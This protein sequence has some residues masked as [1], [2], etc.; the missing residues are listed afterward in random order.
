NTATFQGGVYPNGNDTTY[1][2]QYG[3]TTSYGQTTPNTDIG[4]GTAP[5]Q[6]SDTITGLAP[7]TTYHYQ[8][9]AVSPDTGTEFPGYD[10]TFT[11]SDTGN[12]VGSGGAGG[13]GG[14]GGGG[15]GGGTGDGAGGSTGGGGTTG[16]SGGSG[17]GGGSGG[18]TGITHATN[19]PQ[20]GSV[21][22]QALGS[23]SATV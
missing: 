15:T 21:R 18:Q 9:V 14:S 7:N 11:T 13:G 16:G 1:F 12:S 2:W 23:S 3:T 19:A 22:I 4:D 8:L 5:V 6:V 17:N 10:F 20:F